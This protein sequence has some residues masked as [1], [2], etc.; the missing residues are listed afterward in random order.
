MHLSATTDS[1]RVYLKHC[2]EACSAVQLHILDGKISVDIFGFPDEEASRV[3]AIMVNRA[4]RRIFGTL[5]VKSRNLAEET[6]SKRYNMELMVSFDKLQSSYWIVN[7]FRVPHWIMIYCIPSG[8][9]FLKKVFVPGTGRDFRP[10]IESPFRSR[11][12]VSLVTHSSQDHREEALSYVDMKG[13][14]RVIVK[15]KELPF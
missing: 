10:L 6:F 1:G 5:E 11:T 15:K 13:A 7:R 2:W 12:E 3:D 9:A 4:T 8:V 14:E